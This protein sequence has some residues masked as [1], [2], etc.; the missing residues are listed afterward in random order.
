MNPK[1]IFTV[2]LILSA[3]FSYNF[4]LAYADESTT[5]AQTVATD[6]TAFAINLYG[7]L[8]TR[9]GNLCFSPYSIS[10]ALAMAYGGA[11]NRTAEQIAQ[12]LHFDLPPDK[13]HPAF[14][15]LGANLNAVQQKGRVELATANSLWPQQG[16]GF[17]P[18]YLALCQKDYGTSITPVDYQNHTEEAR[19]T[20]NYWV[21][22]RTKGKITELLPPGM[23][24]SSTRLTL[25]NAIYFKGK[26]ASPFETNL[27]ANQPFHLS[28]EQSITAPL[29]RQTANFGY[30][31]FPGLQ[32]IELPYA[33]GNLS[34]IVLLPDKID[35][36]DSF[37]AELTT[38]NLASWTTDLLSQKVIVSL[39]KFKITSKFS[40]A[41]TLAK[42]GITDAFQSELA[43]FSGMDGQKDLFI[44]VV[45]HKAF[46]EVNEEGTEAAAATAV[47]VNFGGAS[48][49]PPPTPVF[50]ADHP[51][52]FLIRDNHSGSVLFLGRVTNPT[53]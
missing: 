39:P 3:L 15:E 36:L 21:E 48:I 42:M 22:I 45:E 38:Q 34:M 10:T 46:V 29:M 51:F 43:D 27:T 47:L 23:V 6:N 30:A 44:N 26:W 8:R 18:D 41:N 12:T 50:R 2:V 31:E 53:L 33:G 49:N 13:L 40:L 5:S 32:V 14:A 52:L 24:S 16:F 35:G 11:R 19:K 17:L 20:I 9:A 1:L 7:Q 4:N 28:P 25:V 37:E